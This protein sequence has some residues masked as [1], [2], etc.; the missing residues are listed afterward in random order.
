MTD[1]GL[2]S[3]PYLP[4]LRKPHQAATPKG[5]L[6]QAKHPRSSSADRLRGA[7]SGR[8]GVFYVNCCNIENTF[9]FS[10]LPL[11]ESLNKGRP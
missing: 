8:I 3:R 7:S 6:G 1:L 5:V 2:I 11:V 4:V 10:P 9:S